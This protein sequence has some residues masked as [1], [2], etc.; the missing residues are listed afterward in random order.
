M[1]IPPS[2]WVAGPLSPQQLNTDLISFDG[3]GF[4]PNGVVFHSHRPVLYETVLGSRSLGASTGGSWST[5]A[6]TGTS[7]FSVLDTSALYS[8][9]ADNPGVYAAYSFTP[10]VNGSAGNAN[11]VG[12]YCLVT[13]YMTASAAQGTP[14]ACGA[15]LSVAGTSST[16]FYSQGAIQ[17]Q[18]TAKT[19]CAPFVDIINSASSTGSSLV[20]VS[21]TFTTSG[22]WVA[23]AGVTSVQA[24]CWGGGGGGGGGNVSGFGFALAAGGGGGGEYAAN[25]TYTVV[26]GNTY[27]FTIGAAGAAGSGS[28]GGN[29]GNTI[30]DTTGSGVTANGGTGGGSGSS[31]GGGGAAGTGSSAPAH[32]SGG[33][34]AGGGTGTGGGGGGSG[35]TGSAGNNGSSSGTGGAAVTGG[36]PGGNG[37]SGT[38][39]APVSGP[40][41]GGGGGN[42]SGGTGGAGAS[43]QITLTWTQVGGATVSTSWEPSAFVA[44]GSATTRTPPA[45]ATD[46]AGTTSRAL[47]AWAGVSTGGGTVASVPTPQVTWPTITTTLLNGS[48]GPNQALTFLNDPPLIRVAQGLTTSI[49]SGTNTTVSYGTAATVVPDTYSGWNGTTAYT[50]KLPGL[51]LFSPV[52]PFA[53]SSAGQRY[54]GLSVN[55]TAVTLQG[56]SYAPSLIPS[57][58]TSVTQVRILDL[59]A[60]DTV[61]MYAFQDS[62]GAVALSSSSS[63]TTRLTGMMLCPLST[64]SGALTTAPPNTAFRWSAGLTPSQLPGLLNL[65]LGSDLSFLVNRPYFTGYQG[66]AQTGFSNNT[67]NNVTIDTVGGLIHASNGDNYAGWSSA[68]NAY[69]AQQPGWYLV[70]TEVFATVPTV[71]TGYLTAGIKVASSGGISPSV[72]PDSYQSVFFPLTSAQA[73][74]ASAIGLYYLAAGESVSPVIRADNWIS[75]GTWGTTSSSA[76]RSQFTVVW[77]CE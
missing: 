18:G 4:T 16:T 26:P 52:V 38:G 43:G 70:I 12:G 27:T 22:T 58:V 21:Q 44:D 63:Y 66:T 42:G 30:F 1:P 15:G 68:S 10:T 69:I 64:G 31:G 73:P 48:T 61:S 19:A 11:V 74:G 40:G 13:L 36:G 24:Q 2:T 3:T 39:S 46:T 67:W 6:G 14:A 50:A 59:N 65:H 41:G 35:G 29:G 25:L 75:A 23:P 51:Y 57:G 17:T 55:G 9:G 72:S 62:G 33:A 60:N 47:F 7:A 5:I 28:T 76:V 34:G 56:P 71:T 77:L 53:S 8:P 20:T 45:N 32:F 49:S 54:C 37:G